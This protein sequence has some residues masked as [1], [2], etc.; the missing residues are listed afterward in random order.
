MASSKPYEGQRVTSFQY[1]FEFYHAADMIE[2]YDRFQQRAKD[3]S[4]HA[5]S[6]HCPFI[7]MEGSFVW[8]IGCG[9]WT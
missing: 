6:T 2:F 5:Q 1:K 9:W 4:I 8:K 7:L 3:A